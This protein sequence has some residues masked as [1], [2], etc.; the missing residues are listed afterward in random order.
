[1]GLLRRMGQATSDRSDATHIAQ[2]MGQIPRMRRFKR[3]Q[4]TASGWSPDIEVFQELMNPHRDT[5]K[6][7]RSS[8]GRWQDIWELSGFVMFTVLS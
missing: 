1:M 4:L 2:L 7:S 6:Y 3:F 8:W 5:S